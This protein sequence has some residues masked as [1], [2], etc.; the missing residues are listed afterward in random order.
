LIFV[1]FA[2]FCGDINFQ[3]SISALPARPGLDSLMDIEYSVEVHRQLEK[4]FEKYGL[5]R[6]MHLERYEAGTY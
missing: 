5:H 3:V 2:P 6:P 4:E 1:L